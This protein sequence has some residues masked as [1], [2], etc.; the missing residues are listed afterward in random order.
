[1]SLKIIA[2]VALHLM[3]CAAAASAAEPTPSEIVQHCYYKYAGDDQ[4]SQLRITLND[5][6]GKKISNEFTRLWKDYKGQNGLVD[7]TILYMTYPPDSRGLNFMRWSYVSESKVP[8]QWVYLPELRMARRISQRDPENMDWGYTDED[9]RI[10]TLDEDA[11]RYLGTISQESQQYYLVESTPK[12]NSSYSRRVSW[13]SKTLDWED[14]VESRVDYYDKQNT[15]IKKQTVRWQ[16]IKGAWAW[17]TAV[18]Q[19][20]LS[21]ATVVYDMEQVEVNVGLKDD[22]FNQRALRQEGAR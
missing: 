22:D 11:H 10:R 9:L 20:M 3:A 5:P 7:K 16:K 12:G 18:A 2:P 21:K 4:R 13:F 17:K 8:D 14:C 19:N 15:L 6:V 1:M